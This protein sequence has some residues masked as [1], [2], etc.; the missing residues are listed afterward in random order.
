MTLKSCEQDAVP[1]KL[2]K[3]ILPSVISIITNIVNISLTEGLY[4]YQWKTTIIK[5]KWFRAPT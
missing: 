5:E 3:D 1:T 4:S 2:L